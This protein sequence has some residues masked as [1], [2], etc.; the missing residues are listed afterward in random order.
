MNLWY[1][2]MHPG[3]K[4]AID[5]KTIKRLLSKYGVIGLGSEWEN[6]DGSPNP[7]PNTFRNT[8]EIGDVVAVYS[9]NSA[10]KC[11]V[12]LVR[13]TSDAYESNIKDK[14]CWFDLVRSVDVLDQDAALWKDRFVREGVG[15]FNEG[16]FYAKTLSPANNSVFIN[17]WWHAI[18]GEAVMK[19]YLSLLSVAK[20]IVFTGAPGTGKTYLA[21]Q[22][23]QKMILGKVVDD[24]SALTEEE[25][26]KL[27]EQMGFVQFH[28]SYDYTDF[29][30]GL[31]PVKSE[32]GKSLGFER[33]D[34][35]FKA[36]CWRAAQKTDSNFDAVYKKFV[37]ELLENHSEDNPLELKTEGLGASFYVYPNSNDSLNLM[38]GPSKKK[39]GSLTPEKIKTF[40]TDTPYKWWAGY[41][42]GVLNHLRKKYGLSSEVR[43]EERPYVFIID[44]IN[45][46]DVSKIFGELFFAIDKGYRGKAEGCPK[47]QYDNLI[48]PG[49]SFYG[50]FYVPENV[51]IIGTMNDVDRNVES[52]D[53]AI[54]RRFTW[55]KVMPSERFEAMWTNVDEK[56][57]AL[58]EPARQRMEKLNEA[59]KK[60]DGLGEAYQIGPAYFRGLESYLGSSDPF[61]DLWKFHLQPLVSEYLR[62]TPNAEERVNDLKSVYDNA[63]TVGDVEQ[64]QE[65]P[66][67]DGN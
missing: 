44:E 5:A 59:I 18:Q 27:E 25:R 37:D 66:T 52:M 53:F 24:E 61:G 55:L 4:N 19:E 13:V 6:K 28:P 9:S 62:G 42:R 43:K 54:R 12:A 46:G 15:N 40:L 8:M 60:V 10:D 33:R 2:Q 49:E 7:T 11:F 17:Y 14:A 1:M 34:G 35:A 3:D 36:F 16:I 57:A 39:Q 32:D 31:R 58:K 23:A 47:T 26:A 50:G 41:Y 22:I 38:T 51:Y 20:Q 64:N 45:R 30:E 65:T 63:E 48:E 67:P 29:V 56:L 21:R